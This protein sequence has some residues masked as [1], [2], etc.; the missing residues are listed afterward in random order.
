[1][2]ERDERLF[3]KFW[4]WFYSTPDGPDH[5]WRG[6][7]GQKDLSGMTMLPGAI[8]TTTPQKIKLTVKLKNNNPVFIPLNIVLCTINGGD[9]KTVEELSNVAKEDIDNVPPYEL[10][11]DGIQYHVYRLGP[12]I[13][14]L[15]VDQDIAVKDFD[16]DNGPIP[17][18]NT[19]AATDGYY[20][21]LPAE[22][23]KG[24][25]I[26]IKGQEFDKSI[27]VTYDVR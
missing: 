8:S 1:M 7:I 24:K 2:V 12:H 13:F 6:K 19:A 25:T 17:L 9:G 10:K 15:R 26:T 3:E 11:I 27:D 5:P 22:A 18:G 21:V 4:V 16:P 23:V 20:I 14:T